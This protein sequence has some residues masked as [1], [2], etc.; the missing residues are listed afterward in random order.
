M[1]L[2]GGHKDHLRTGAAPHRGDTGR[3]QMRGDF[4]EDEDE[5]NGLDLPEDADEMWPDADLED[6]ISLPETNDDEP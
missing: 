5:D 3:L 6:D 4:D 2:R 1:A